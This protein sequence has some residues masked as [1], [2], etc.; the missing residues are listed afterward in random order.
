MARLPLTF[1]C[2]PYDRMEALNL[3][4]VQAEGIDLRYI[5]I[6]SPPEIFARM[7]KTGSF[8]AA[9]MSLAHYIVA[10]TRGSFPFVA[11]PV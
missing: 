6:Q 1:A 3:G 11:I 5:A 9:E 10:R 8:D 4:A 7:A 2:G